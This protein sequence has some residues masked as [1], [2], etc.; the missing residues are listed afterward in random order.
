ME[1]TLSEAA[2]ALGKTERQLRYAIKEG[3][4]PARMERR[5]W[6]VK[7]SDLPL[8]DS[9]RAA[10][11]AQVR[12]A[13]TAFEKGL[14][15]AA[16]ATE[17]K[18]DDKTYSVTDLIAFQSGIEVHEDFVKKLGAD[19]PACAQLV[20]ALTGVSKGCHSFH[21]NDK[22][23]HF[24]EARDRMATLIAELLLHVGKGRETRQALARRVERELI[25]KV[26]GLVARQEKR[27][28]GSRFERFGSS[29]RFERGK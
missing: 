18:E 13:R 16:K 6:I 11:A 23:R 2:V 5:R 21:P 17:A 27:S 1:L 14:E 25:P 8:S 4:L 26:A 29:P 15:P 24:T 28:R 3:E 22:A 19:D 7:S 12:T 10:M 20:A 9:Q